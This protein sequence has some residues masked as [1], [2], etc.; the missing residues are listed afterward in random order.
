MGR[1]RI[2]ILI[3]DVDNTL[4]DWVSIW[5]ASFS[6]L[7]ESM[8]E[9]SG[10]PRELL[11]QEIRRIHQRVGTSEYAFLIQDLS[12][13]ADVHSTTDYLSLYEP[14]IAESR[15]ARSEAMRLYPG[16]R[17]TLQKLKEAGIP[18]IAYTE[19]K[20]FYTSLRFRSLELDGLIDVLYSPADHEISSSINLGDVRQY[21]DDFYRLS[22]TTHRHTPAGHF[23][24]DPAVLA[25]IVRDFGMDVTATLYVGDSLTKDIAMAQSLTIRDAFAAYGVAQF[26]ESYE[27][28]R[29]VSHWSDEDVERERKLL[30]LP[31][32]KPSVSLNE[33]SEI[34]S[35]FDFDGQ[36]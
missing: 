35:H 16:V 25:S 5:Y 34:L 13:L 6:A 33:F 7:L 9:I 14:A 15:R 3:T 17:E 31:V 1:P 10:L 26:R 4:Y 19:S 29:R 11:E 20:A 28:L 32:V 36:P 8:I 18:L 21:P 12:I 22:E 23:K 27:L 24:P 2:R 30:E